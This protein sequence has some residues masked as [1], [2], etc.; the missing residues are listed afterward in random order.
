MMRNLY[1]VV[2]SSLLFLITAC[3]SKS[4][5]QNQNAVAAPQAYTT[6]DPATAATVRGTIGFNG[7]APAP[8]EI[9]MSADPACQF[10][11]G[12]KSMSEQYVV[13][14]GKL[15][16]VYVYVKEGLEGKNFAPLKAPAVLDQKGCRYHPHVLGMMMDQPL[17]IL[18]SDP[19][20]H[21]VHPSPKV[22]GNHE[23]NISQMPKGDPVEKSFMQPE[24]MM[25]V[26]CNQ[27]NWMKAYINVS[28]TP[29]FAVSDVAGNFEIKGLP[30]G[31]YTIAAV[32]E[33]AGEQ[34]QKITVGPGESK[35]VEFVFGK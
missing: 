13:N 3:N 16:N 8:V 12:G 21:N 9:D 25:P 26:Q 2:L 22:D 6:V 10:A 14:N 29:F 32:H 7:K 18:N 28:R 20:T 35:Q 11:G 27:H 23:W 30:P 5:E 15:A 33:K 31:E 4:S 17:R 1:L 24:I 19:A 34:T